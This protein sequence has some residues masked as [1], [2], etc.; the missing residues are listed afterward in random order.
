[1]YADFPSSPLN[2][3]DTHGPTCV[4]EAEAILFAYVHILGVC[5]SLQASSGNLDLLRTAARVA[6]V[7]VEVVVGDLLRDLPLFNPELE[8]SGVPPPVATWRRALA[9][10]DAVLI[11]SPEYGHSLSGALKNAIDWVIGSGELDNKVVAT[12]AA[13]PHPDRGRR[14]LQALGQT[15]RAVAAVVVGEQPIVR[16]PEFETDVRELLAALVHRATEVNSRR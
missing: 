1:L 2:E 15:L 11:A 6:P 13:V 5:G 3:F 10:S 16:G 7:G 9:A 12:T 14:G 4:A 8:A